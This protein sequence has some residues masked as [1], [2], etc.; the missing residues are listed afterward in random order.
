MNN[1][2]S[3]NKGE[4]WL[5]IIKIK[6]NE[7]IIYDSFGRELAY[8]IDGYKQQTKNT[9]ILTPD[10]DAEQNINDTTCGLRSIAYILFV[11]KYGYKN[12]LF[13]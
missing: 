4:H 6:N 1:K 11:K 12:A 7:F 9:H 8:I 3:T 2:N 5:P 13:I 10:D